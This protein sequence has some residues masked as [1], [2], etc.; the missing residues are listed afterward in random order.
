MKI[1]I[2]KETRG[3]VNSDKSYK[4]SYRVRTEKDPL[5]LAFQKSLMTTASVGLEEL[6]KDKEG[7]LG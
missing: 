7:W 3:I 6:K 1:Q 4:E 2:K 5:D